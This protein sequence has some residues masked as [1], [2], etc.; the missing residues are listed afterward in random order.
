MQATKEEKAQQMECPG[1]AKPQAEHEWL[2]TL[3]GT[4]EAEGEAVMGPDQT[5]QWKS[6]EVVRSIGG[7]WVV[8]EGTGEMP[9]GGTAT[10]IITIGYDPV[11]GKYVGTFIGSMM[12]NM[13]IYEGSLDASGKVLTLDTEGPAMTPEGGTAKYQDIVELKNKDL[14]TLTSRVQGAD[15]KWQQIM[16]AT[17]RRKK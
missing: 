10:T 1:M 5:N 17:Y 15:G 11:K 8:G 9:E 16:T 14:R 3:V 4:W 7:L 2:Q 12:A 13:W 6:T